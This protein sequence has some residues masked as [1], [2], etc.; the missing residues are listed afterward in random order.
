MR[1][2][3]ILNSLNSLQFDENEKYYKLPKDL[4]DALADYF[5]RTVVIKRQNQ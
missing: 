4:K 5:G 1:E 2:E 3:D